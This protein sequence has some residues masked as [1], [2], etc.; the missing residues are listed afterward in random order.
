MITKIVRL[1]HQGRGICYI[2]NKITF[3]ENSLPDEEVDIRIINSKKKFNEGIV[4]KYIKKSNDRIDNVCPYYE[5][6]GG[7]N[8]LHLDYNNQLKYKQNKIVDIMKRFAGLDCVNN[9]IPCDNQFNYRN[10]VVFKVYNNK[11]GYYERRT[12]KIVEI[13][14]CRLIDNSF[15]NIINDISKFDLSNINEIMIRNI[16]SQNTAL[17]LYLQKM[18]KHVQIEDYCKNNNII[19][20]QIIKNNSNKVNEKSKIIARLNNYKY[21]VSP[22]SFFQVNTNQTIKLYDKIVEFLEPDINDNVLDLYCGT[23]TIGIYVSKY[24]KKVLGIEI[25]NDAIRDANKNKEINHLDNIEFLCGDTESVIKNVNSK[26]NKIIVD[27][28]RAGLTNSVINDILRLNPDRVVYVSC[29]PITLARD[30]KILNEKYDIKD[31]TPVD[32]FPNTFHVE[33]VA[34]MDRK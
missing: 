26:F 19:L 34:V 21:L 8:L 17:T 4:V 15:N 10:K 9:I 18:I 23:G 7:C 31:I 6:C 11:I 25:I 20:T 5:K 30:L 13:N 2:D 1:D 29:D 16:N 33:C 12:N 3:V 22:L 32:M 27:P 28:P 24:V 14:N